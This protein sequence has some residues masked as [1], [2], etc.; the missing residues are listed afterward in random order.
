[1]TITIHGQTYI[2]TSEQDVW[3]LLRHLASRKA[4]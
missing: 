4:S 2:V 1:M 3:H